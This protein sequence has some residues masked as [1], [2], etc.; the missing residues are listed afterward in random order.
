VVQEEDDLG[1]GPPRSGLMERASFS[2]G[3]RYLLLAVALPIF[4]IIL[5]EA[6]FFLDELEIP[7]VFHGLNILYCFIVPLLLG[8]PPQVYQAFSLVSLLRIV[9]IGM[10]V[11]FDLTIYWLPFIYLPIIIVALL[12]AWQGEGRV[13][14]WSMMRRF[15][16]KMANINKSHLLIY[17]ALALGLG[18][19]L[20][21]IE[22]QLLKP[23][24]LIADISLESLL[25][26]FVVMIFFVGLG[27][28]LVFRFLLQ[29]RMKARMGT[30]TAIILASFV[31]ALMHSGYSSLTFILYV[32]LIGMV[33]GVSYERTRSLA[34]VALLHG[35]INFFLFSVFP[36]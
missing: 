18:A 11:F 1:M 22:Y 6:F 15:L 23:E 17:L 8:A 3:P 19:V 21:F 34:F 27:E 4:F 14:P 10:P 20:G 26:L 7:L 16:G 30:W 9:N 33:F 31:F 5:G 29:D 2:S 28:E 12:L 32:F 24:R 35:A 25:L 36:Y 13:S